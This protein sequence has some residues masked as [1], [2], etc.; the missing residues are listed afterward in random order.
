MAAYKN[1]VSEVKL[2][3]EIKLASKVKLASKI[4]L[5]SKVKL[6]SK[7]VTTIVEEVARSIEKVGHSTKVRIRVIRKLYIDTAVYNV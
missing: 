6:A 5:A 4:K 3:S 7:A 2:A 1:V